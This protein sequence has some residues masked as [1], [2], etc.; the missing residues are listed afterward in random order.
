MISRGTTPTLTFNIPS[1]IINKI[2]EGTILY[3]TFQQVGKT[4]LEKT[5]DD[6]MIDTEKS[7]IYFDMTQA[8]SLLFSFNLK[9]EIQIRIKFAD[10]KAIK[11][12]IITTTTDR[13]LKVGEI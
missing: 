1:A 11:S 3:I 6:V 4:V 10:E 8:E 9:I 5:K 7:T 2:D 12:S 13:L